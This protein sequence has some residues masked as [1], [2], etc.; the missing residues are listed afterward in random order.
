MLNSL[1]LMQMGQPYEPDL[2]NG[3]VLDEVFYPYHLS[4]IE[5]DHKDIL[6]IH[7]LGFLKGLF[8][9]IP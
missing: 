3:Q 7:L 1:S 6:E 8:N 9:F 5:L 2:I 4:H